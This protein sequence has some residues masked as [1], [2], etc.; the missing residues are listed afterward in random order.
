MDT[1]YIQQ[2]TGYSEATVQSTVDSFVK[3]I[4][5]ELR[6]GNEVKVPELG[7]FY[8][9][10]LGER[11]SRNPRTG[12]EIIAKPKTKPRLRFYDSFEKMIQNSGETKTPK[13]SND[14]SNSNSHSK[15][16]APPPLPSVPPPVPP[17]PSKT[18][19]IAKPD[20]T[21]ATRST[22]EL[23][24]ILTPETFVWTEGQ[25]GWKAAQDVPELSPLFSS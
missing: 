24:G 3:F 14:N 1:S 19:H 2:V 7:V 13:V 21:I 4:Q 20:G 5:N 12:E 6:N 22:S 23:K 16:I 15:T 17:V 9:K 11:K 8:S 25:E 10:E 18:W